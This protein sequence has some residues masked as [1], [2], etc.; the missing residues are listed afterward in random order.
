MATARW[1]ILLWLLVSIA[2]AVITCGVKSTLKR[3]R[4]AEV[5]GFYSKGYD[6]HAFPSRHATRMGTLS[7]MGT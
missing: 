2:A 7:V 3:P 1:Q 6:R 5:N 4:P